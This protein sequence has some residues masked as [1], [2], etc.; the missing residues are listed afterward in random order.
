MRGDIVTSQVI[1]PDLLRA[2]AVGA[3]LL[4]RDLA[5]DELLV[6]R[7]GGLLDVALGDRVLHRRR[8]AVA[9]GRADRER[10][11]HRLDD[12]LEEQM[13]LGRLELLRVLLGLGERAEVRLE[14]LAHRRLDAAEPRSL[15]EHREAQL[16]LRRAA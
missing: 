5:A 4:D 8:L 6:D 9:D 11:L 12:P 14:L 15:D 10:Q 3:L 13:A 7:L 16:A 2:A 1:A